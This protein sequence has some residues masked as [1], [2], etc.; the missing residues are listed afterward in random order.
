M[1]GAKPA[2]VDSLPVPRVARPFFTVCVPKSRADG[3]RHQTLR[4]VQETCRTPSPALR[5][6]LA[7]TTFTPGL[8]PI[9]DECSRF[10]MFLIC[11]FFP[12]KY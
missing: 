11:F 4:R 2:S 12:L 1:L 7:P 8:D 3:R 9:T 10:D 5:D 6:D